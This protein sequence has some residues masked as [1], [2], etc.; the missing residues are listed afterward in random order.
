MTSACRGSRR[1]IAAHTKLSVPDVGLSLPR[2]VKPVLLTTSLTFEC[3]SMNDND[4]ISRI[5]TVWTMLRQA[6]GDDSDAA[7]RAVEQTIERYSGAVYRYLLAVLQ[8]QDAAD[9]VFQQFALRIV[10]GAF[11][12]ADPDRG[13]FRD[14]LK[15]SVLRLVADYRR[16]RQKDNRLQSGGESPDRETADPQDIDEVFRSSWSEEL[17]S[18]A[19]R[20]LLEMEQQSGQPFFSVLQHRA[21]FPDASR[22]RMAADLTEDLQPDR[23]LTEA[24]IR[25]TLQ[26]A[27]EQF[28]DLLIAEVQKS[29][30]STDIDETEQELIDLGL[31][32]YSRSAIDRRR[33]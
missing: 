4:R 26:R 24:G 3:G 21:R 13:R 33:M 11:H 32:S 17:L 28:A 22:A 20:S 23:P 7:Q 9:E 30:D 10:E 25:K 15:V 18:L 16:R 31:H 29:I 19:W 14:Y 1:G 12:R 6:H 8:D 5:S 2:D 27:R